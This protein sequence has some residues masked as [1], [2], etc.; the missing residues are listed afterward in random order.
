MQDIPSELSRNLV[1]G[2]VGGLLAN[3]W[4]QWTVGRDV[5][6]LKTIVKIIAGKLDI[7][8]D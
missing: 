3:L 8:V 2:V 6:R 1:S 7:T 5:A 4:A